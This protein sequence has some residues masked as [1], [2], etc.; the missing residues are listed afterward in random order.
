M[1]G[2][3]ACF[4]F[5]WPSGN[6]WDS[7]P[8]FVDI[9]LNGSFGI[10]KYPSAVKK[11]NIDLFVFMRGTIITGKNNKGIII[12]SISLSL[13]TISPTCSSK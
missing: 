8:S 13:A 11:M 6:R 3:C 9:S 2:L 12:F 1:I 4:D 10:D 7:D 5:T